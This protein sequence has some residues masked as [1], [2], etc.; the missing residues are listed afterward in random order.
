MSSRAEQRRQQHQ[1]TPT[2]NFTEQQI[3]AYMQPI[4]DKAKNDVIEETILKLTYMIA[5]T[6]N[7]EF[8]FGAKRINRF[9]GRLFYKAD[10]VNEGLVKID[11]IEKWCNEN[12]IGKE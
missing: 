1:K 8:D 2:Y 4:I 10:C 5:Q 11:D 7:D 9:L 6:L 12:K 3:I